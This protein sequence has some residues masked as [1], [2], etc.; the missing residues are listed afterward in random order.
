MFNTIANL[1]EGMKEAENG[2]WDDEI[3]EGGTSKLLRTNIFKEVYQLA[4]NSIWYKEFPKFEKNMRRLL[5]R[6]PNLLGEYE[7][8]VRDRKEAEK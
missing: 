6:Q 5:S 1:P 7:Q 3:K 4:E 2:F 8:F